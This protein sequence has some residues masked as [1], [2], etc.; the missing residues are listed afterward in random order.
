MEDDADAMEVEAANVLAT[1][2]PSMPVPEHMPTPAATKKDNGILGWLLIAA[3]AAVLVLGYMQHWWT[4]ENFK[5]FAMPPSWQALTPELVILLFAVLAP[6][7]GL[8]NSTGRDMRNFAVVGL[9]GALFLCASSLV[10]WTLNIGSFSVPFDY[11]ARSQDALVAGDPVAHVLSVTYASQ[12]LKVLFLGVAFIAILGVGKP[13]KGKTEEDWGEFVSLILFA[14]LGMMVV[15]SARDLIVLVLG[16]EMTSMSSYVLA[17]F[18]RDAVGAEASLKYFTIG[19]I[20]SGLLLFAVSLLY[21]MAGTTNIASL[22][23]AIRTHGAF[24]AAMLIPIVML[25]AGLGFKISSVPFHAWAPDVYAGAPVPVAGMLAA[26]SKAMGFAA[27]FSVF[28]I[29]LPGAHANWELVVAVIAV[30]SMFF[31]NLVAL[32]QTNIRRMLAYSSIAQAGYVLI[33]VVAAGAVG[34]S[35]ANQASLLAQKTATLALGGG[36]FHLLANAAMKLGAFLIVG[37]LLYAGLPDQISDWRGLGKRAPFLAFAMTLFLLS[38]AGLPPLGGFASKFVLFSGAVDAGTTQHM[39]WLTW[40]AIIAVINSAISLFVYLRV[41]RA[42]YVDEGETGRLDAPAGTI[43]AVGVC[44]LLILA[45]GVW[46][47]PF[48]DAS[49]R[50]AAN[51]LGFGA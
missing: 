2:S 51:F 23:T 26:A 31:G 4:S 24:D 14:T 47:Q 45:M 49:F 41:M 19:A 15:A 9:G 11:I 21:G 10:S 36:F 13:L 28:L 42:M 29:G 17:G 35:E 37:A 33:A 3:L 48:M 43:A 22:A 32:Q 20:S 12:L 44:A 34:G 40:L 27:I 46:P 50:A 5:H 18:R 30:A 8:G 39:G 1:P 38:M 16:I 7:V 25:L 6:L